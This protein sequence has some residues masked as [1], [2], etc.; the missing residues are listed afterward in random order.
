MYEFSYAAFDIAALF[1]GRR[2]GK[3]TYGEL[4]DIFVGLEG[5]ADAAD[6]LCSEICG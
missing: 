5:Q 6:L 1:S 4:I 2:Y 3:P